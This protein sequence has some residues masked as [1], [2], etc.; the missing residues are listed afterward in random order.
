MGVLLVILAI[1]NY[2]LALLLIAV[3]GFILQGVN[4]TGA[5][6]PEAYFFVALIIAA[7][8][9]PT[10]VLLMRKRLTP[11]T[12]IGIAAAPLLF[13]AAALLIGPS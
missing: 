10:F 3:S 7:V 6:L 4:N 9:A 2:A 11:Q 8:V 5:M 12:A 13:A 1:A